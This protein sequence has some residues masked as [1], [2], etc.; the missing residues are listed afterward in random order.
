M[1]KPELALSLGGDDK[2]RVWEIKS[3]KNND[4]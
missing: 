2:I 4:E 3:I 1:F